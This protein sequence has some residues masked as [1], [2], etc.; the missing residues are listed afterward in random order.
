MKEGHILQRFGVSGIFMLVFLGTSAVFA[1]AAV[2][3]SRAEAAPLS[4][5][6]VVKGEWMPLYEEVYNKKLRTYEVSKDGWGVI[7]YAA[8]R[9]GNEGVLVGEDGWLFTKEEFDYQ[10]AQQENITKNLKYIHAVHD[11]LRSR[12][13]EL[14][15]MPVPAKA[16]VYRDRLGRYPYPAYKQGVYQL[17]LSDL[18]THQISVIDVLAPMEAAKDAPVFL[19]TD[20]HWTPEGARIAAETAAQYIKTELPVPLEQAAYQTTLQKEEIHKGDLLRYIPVGKFSSYFRLPEDRLGVFETA[21]TSS[22]SGDMSAALF[23]DASPAVTLVGTSYSANSKWNFEGFLKE[24]LQTDILNAADEGLGPFET[25][26]KYLDNEAFRKT[27]PKLVIWEM[28][29]RYL[30]FDYDLK[31]NFDTEGV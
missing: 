23:S 17:L 19:K 21:S 8:F 14:V 12:G 30:S 1:L 4:L 29:E 7:N 9:E 26:Q 3:Q 10:P 2:W 16:R 22:D 20:T 5:G 28:P 24:S 25:M 6:R 15:V 11:H 13:I 31:M 18:L 27:P